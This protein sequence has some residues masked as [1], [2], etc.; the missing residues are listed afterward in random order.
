MSRETKIKKWILFGVG[1]LIALYVLFPFYLVVLNSFKVQA[2]IVSSPISFKGASFSQFVSNLSSV[3]NNSNFN[4]WRALFSSVVITVISLALLALFGAMAGWVIS[5]NN[6]TKWATAI[7]LI[8][9]F[10]TMDWKLTWIVW[11]VAGV[12]YAAY[13]EVM[14]AIIRAR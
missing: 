10:A 2:D 4:F 12:L 1:V 6:K 11:P 7:Y 8:W 9:S 3:V 13:H 14:K 5:R